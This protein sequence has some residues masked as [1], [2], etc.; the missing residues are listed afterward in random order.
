MNGVK[1]DINFADHLT[2]VSINGT[3]LPNV[4]RVVYES[5]LNDAKRLKVEVLLPVLPET[6]GQISFIGIGRPNVSGVFEVVEN[7][8]NWPELRLNGTKLPEVNRFRLMQEP[9]ELTLVTVGFTDE[10][11]LQGRLKPV[12]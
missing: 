10:S 9:G 7:G 2:K 6:K 11:I 1:V 5:P 4:G 8:T 12:E 3:P